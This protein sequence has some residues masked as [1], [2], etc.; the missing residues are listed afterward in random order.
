MLLTLFLAFI[1][2][3]GGGDCGCEDKP[4]VNTLAV[5]NGVKIT[6]AQLG[7]DAQNRITQ[8]Q[9]EVIK[10]RGAALDLR[11]NALL[12]DAEAKR[13]GLTSDQLL[14]LE[15]RDKVT[16]PSEAEVQAF[17]NER[18]QQIGKDF[19]TVRPDII[20]LFKAEHESLES[21]RF[22]MAL[23]SAANIV[24]VNSNVTPPVSEEDLD[25]VFATINGRPITSRDIEKSLAPL[26]FK[27]QEQVYTIRKQDLDQRINDL[28]LEHEANA[29]NTTAESLL[30]NEVRSKLPIITDQQARSYYEANRNKLSLDFEKV[31]YLIIQ[32]LLSAEE[33]K[34]SAAYAARLRENAAV[35]IYLTPP[36]TSKFRAGQ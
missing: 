26:I 1:F 30:A 7:S 27:V 16:E 12:L 31:K 19:K 24:V 25:R 21:A 4:Q 14:Q 10:A 33:K 8:L 18:K 13:R 15:V 36:E 28:L 11:I 20:A 34:L 17:Y 29:R 2:Q 22:A 9:G 23:R 35:Q 6:K 5:V 32:Y 3:F